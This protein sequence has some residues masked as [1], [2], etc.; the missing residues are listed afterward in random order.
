[1]N[2]CCVILANTPAANAKIMGCKLF[3]SKPNEGSTEGY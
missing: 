3:F 1:M 2:W